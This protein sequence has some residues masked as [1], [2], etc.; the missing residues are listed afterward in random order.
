MGKLL[1][2]VL[3]FVPLA[4]FA[5]HGDVIEVQL[6]EDCS[7]A[8]YLEIK[9]DFNQQWGKKN[10]YRAEVYVPIQSDNLISLYWVGKSANA[11]AFGKAWDQWRNDLNKSDSV[12]SKLWGRFQACSKNVSRNGYDVL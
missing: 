2:F 11:A 1:R 5:D 3:L 6:N 7:V 9:D 8:K 10:G 12:A 4:A